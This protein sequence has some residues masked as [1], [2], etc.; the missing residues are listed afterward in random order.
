MFTSGN[1]R[2]IIFDNLLST[3]HFQDPKT[4]VNSKVTFKV[5]KYKFRQNKLMIFRRAELPKTLKDL[6]QRTPNKRV[7]HFLFAQIR[8]Q[9][10]WKQKI[11]KIKMI[12]YKVQS[13]LQIIK[14]KLMPIL[15]NNLNNKRKKNEFDFHHFITKIKL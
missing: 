4:H 9:L 3:F 11:F 5:M 12:F 14:R 2:I 15:Q 6:T 1:P 13:S 8:E 10:T 7:Y